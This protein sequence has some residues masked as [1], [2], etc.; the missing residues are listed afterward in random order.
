MVR[1]LVLSLAIGAV[2]GL[3]GSLAFWWADGAV[4]VA[5]LVVTILAGFYVTVRVARHRLFP[6][7]YLE[8]SHKLVG[9][10]ESPPADSAP[11]ES[12]FTEAWLHAV[13]AGDWDTADRLLAEDFA[14]DFP[15]LGK[16]FGRARYLRMLRRQRK[17]YP[18]A[19]YSLEEAREADGELWMRVTLRAPQRRGEPIRTEWW[20][21]WRLDPSSERLARIRQGRVVSVTPALP[22][23]KR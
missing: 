21:A 2:V 9:R 13:N 6:R 19:R 12:S 23:R 16:T 5:G 11:A 8:Q 14:V 17:Y 4:E 7:L 18:E 10:G 22:Q 20:E 3:V 15:E 1:F